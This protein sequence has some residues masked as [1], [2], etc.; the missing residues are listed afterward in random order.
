MP[1]LAYYAVRGLAQPIRF[2]LAYLGIEF[3]DK[4]YTER[5]DWFKKDK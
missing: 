1:T 5:D 2:L 3:T 4:H